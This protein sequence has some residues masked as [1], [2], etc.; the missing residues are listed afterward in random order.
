MLYFPETLAGTI[1]KTAELGVDDFSVF[2]FKYI[3]R[4]IYNIV[5]A[6]DD[7]FVD[8]NVTFVMA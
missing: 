7:W 8:T 2:S 4:K 5:I 3:C 6:S 1:S